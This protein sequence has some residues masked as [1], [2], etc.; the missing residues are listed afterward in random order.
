M[1]RPILVRANYKVTGATLVTLE[2]LV[3]NNLPVLFP[4]VTVMNRT[5]AAGSLVISGETNTVFTNQ[6]DPDFNG[7]VTYTPFSS[8][9]L[10]DGQ[11]GLLSGL[12]NRLMPSDY[13][14]TT[15]VTLTNAG[16]AAEILA[17]VIISGMVETSVSPDP[18]VVINV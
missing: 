6:T 10:G 12:P 13:G 17:S 1:L 16:P 7:A 8:F 15:E 18:L 4:E 5:G 11:T 3:G 2:S 14:I 9:S